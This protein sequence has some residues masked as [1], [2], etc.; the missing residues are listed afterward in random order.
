MLDTEESHFYDSD[1]WLG[2][3]S[4]PCVKYR[5]SNYKNAAGRR[6]DP[7]LISAHCEWVNRCIPGRCSRLRTRQSYV[8]MCYFLSSIDELLLHEDDVFKFRRNV[9]AIVDFD[10]TET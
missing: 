3:D 2:V 9:L 1:Q 5:S 4:V 6:E 10:V 8:R 7:K